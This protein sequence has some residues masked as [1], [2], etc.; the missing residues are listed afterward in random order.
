MGDI[1]E[2]SCVIPRNLLCAPC[3]KSGKKLDITSFLFHKNFLQNEWTVRIN[4]RLGACICRKTD[5]RVISKD[6]KNRIIF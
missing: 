6:V 4:L 2:K 5:F 3:L 1:K